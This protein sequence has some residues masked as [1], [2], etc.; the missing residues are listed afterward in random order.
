MVETAVENTGICI[1]SSKEWWDAVLNLMSSHGLE[2]VASLVN[3][4]KKLEL[5]Y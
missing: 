5:N 1:M 3:E 2:L 4:P